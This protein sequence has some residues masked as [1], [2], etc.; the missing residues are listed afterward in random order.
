MARPLIRQRGVRP[1]KLNIQYLHGTAMTGLAALALVFG[2]HSPARADGARGRADSLAAVYAAPAAADLG[3]HPRLDDY[4]RV[5]ARRSPTLR[6]AFYRWQAALEN[7]GYVGAP[8]EP[9]VSYAY[10]VESIETRLGPQNQRFTL[11]Q[12]FPWFG[13]LG[14]QKDMAEDGAQA[15]YHQFESERLKLF[16]QVKVAYFDY[17]YLGREIDITRDNL[18]L[19]RF[20]ESVARA[21]YRVAL[22]QHPDV[23]KAQVELVKLDDRLSTMETM[24]APVSTRLRAA[25]D[26]GDTIA[27]P[28]P[29]SVAV[30]EM[31]ID[32]EAVLASAMVGNADLKMLESLIDKARSG[33]RLA[34]KALL[35]AF[36]VGV[37]YIDTGPAVMPGVADSGKDAWNVNV[38][39]TVPIWFGANRARKAEAAARLRSA[40]NDYGRARNDVRNLVERSVFEYSDARRKTQLYRD[41][42][43][44]KAQQAL[45][46]SYAAYQAGEADFLNVLDAQRELL[47]F[48]LLFERARSNLAI[49]KAQI[50]MITGMEIEAGGESQ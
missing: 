4:L 36:S 33:E 50:E 18:E 17:Y 39:L 10:F 24:I 23:I 31:A 13:T 29:D 49:A 32:R 21:K 1:A 27:L 40:Q 35:P 7:A 34:G 47:G 2:G 42:L 11:R 22:K 19:L 28:I 30:D 25:L 9:S 15:A 38:G 46:A 43:I 20:W 48:Q 6:T 37:D 3:P 41:G 26:L 44:P 8:P 14:A 5:A 16:Y 45:N 12:A